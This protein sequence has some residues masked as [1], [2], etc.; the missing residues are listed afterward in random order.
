M[1][2]SFNL[3]VPNKAVFISDIDKKYEQNRIR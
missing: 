2:K 3:F 1:N